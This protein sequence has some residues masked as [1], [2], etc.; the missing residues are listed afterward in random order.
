M[1]LRWFLVGF[2]VVALGAVW[3]SFNVMLLTTGGPE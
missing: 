2:V 1:R 3:F